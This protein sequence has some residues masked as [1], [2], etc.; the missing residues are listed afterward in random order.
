MKNLSRSILLLTI[1]SIH[2]SV[3]GQV[4][5]V[6][7]QNP[8]D[9]Y[10][11]GGLGLSVAIDGDTLIAGA[12]TTNANGLYLSGVVRIYKSN[13]QDSWE[14]HTELI[15]SDAAARDFFGSPVSLD[16]DT[17]VVGS[18]SDDGLSSNTGSV[19]IFTRTEGVWSQ[20]AKLTASDATE[21]QRFG[22][23]IALD[24]D[25]LVVGADGDAVP[26]HGS[27][28]A[29]VFV[30]NENVWSQQAKLKASDA[31][32]GHEFGTSV[33][34]D[35]ETVVIGANMP[36]GGGHDSTGSAYVFIR[37]TE[38]WSQQAKLKASD[39]ADFDNFGISVAIQNDTIFVGS[40]TDDDCGYNTGSVYIFLRNQGIWSQQVKLNAEDAAQLDGF[41]RSLAISGESI[42]IG[43][44]YNDG[45]G[46]SGSAYLFLK[47]DGG[48]KQQ[49]K[50]TAGDEDSGSGEDFGFAVALSGDVA[51][52]GAFRDDNAG[53]NTGAVYVFKQNADEWN[54]QAK[55]IDY[56]AE[57]DSFGNSV[58]FHDN[59]MIV[60]AYLD[61][62]L[63]YQA[64]AVHSFTLN[65]GAWIHQQKLFADDG[66]RLGR[67]GRSIAI[68]NNTLI[69]GTISDDDEGFNTGAAYIF[70]R[71]DGIWNQQAKLTANDAEA[72]DWF[73]AAVTL[74]GDIAIVGAPLDDDGGFASG[75]AYVFVRNNGNWRQEAKLFAS[76][77]DEDDEFG[78]TL[79]FDGYTAVVGARNNNDA[80]NNSG[81]AY[82]FIHNSGVW[83]QQAKLTVDD[84]T[85]G[86]SF[87]RSVAVSSETIIVGS[88]GS[89]YVFVRKNNNWILQDKLG[90][91]FN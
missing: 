15:P 55:L 8:D 5:Q 11:I 45:S 44:R 20:Q 22:T 54:Q 81:S 73:G 27:G 37:D 67:F 49:Y 71:N 7:I 24:G 6:K 59:T 66:E 80:G 17:S 3:I 32:W 38:L 2:F 70:S 82:V 52:V 86:T 9:G 23:S 34:I 69:V 13:D 72:Q 78:T 47:K 41:G 76:D 58:A 87:G 18:S 85:T 40:Y 79:A 77:S 48:W 57:N 88:S 63:G 31:N 14:L 61:G 53:N 46:G 30:R 26:G 4:P 36:I 68:H 10:P 64:G 51:I 43:A 90:R 25:T 56:D 84:A 42:I 50:F 89:A 28:A 33:A 16:G 29:Y 1:F 83:I 60:G 35:G 21:G 74:F 91:V 12:P 19:Y 75:S 39:P 65:N 62:D